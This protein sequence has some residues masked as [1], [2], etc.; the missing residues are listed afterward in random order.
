MIRALPDTKE[1]IQKTFVEIKSK[2][3]KCLSQTVGQLKKTQSTGSKAQQAH[4][5]AV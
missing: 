4:S 3:A 1:V 5:L 2:V